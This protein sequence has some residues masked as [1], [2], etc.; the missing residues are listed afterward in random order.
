MQ[1]TYIFMSVKTLATI[2]DHPQSWDISSSIKQAHKSEK[3]Q[4]LE[5]RAVVLGLLDR[6]PV[7]MG[8]P[9]G[10]GKHKQVVS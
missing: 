5:K 7:S 2:R 4:S 8:L 10:R 1:K 3:T 6:A 9:E